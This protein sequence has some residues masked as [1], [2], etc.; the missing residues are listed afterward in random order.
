MVCP[1]V[2]LL[3]K[4]GPGAPQGGGRDGGRGRGRG[5][6]ATQVKTNC[7]TYQFPQANQLPVV[8]IATNHSKGLSSIL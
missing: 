6:R 1:F 3:Q 7:V 8:T 2:I 5:R 4:E